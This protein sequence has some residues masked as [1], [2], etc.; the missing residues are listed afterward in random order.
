MCAVGVGHIATA[1]CKF[2]PP[3]LFGE[4]PAPVWQFACGVGHDPDAV[5]FIEVYHRAGVIRTGS[6]REIVNFWEEQ[7]WAP[8]GG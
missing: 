4:C 1:V 6:G 7:I 3:C 2:I 8:I 5:R